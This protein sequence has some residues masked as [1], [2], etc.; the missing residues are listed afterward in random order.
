MIKDNRDTN[1]PIL[2]GQNGVPYSNEIEIFHPPP[3]N[4]KSDSNETN[5][6]DDNQNVH[7]N[8]YKSDS[9]ENNSCSEVNEDDSEDQEHYMVYQEENNDIKNN[10]HLP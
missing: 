2:N 7:K 4:P 5:S 9:D 3:D 10:I 6:H 1:S 8:G